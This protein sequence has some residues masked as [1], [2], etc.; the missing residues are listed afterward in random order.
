MLD[1]QPFG[2]ICENASANFTLP[3]DPTFVRSL[4]F[5]AKLGAEWGANG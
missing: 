2:T 3:F 1:Q 4:S 5:Q